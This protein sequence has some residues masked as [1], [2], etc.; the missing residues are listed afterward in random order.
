MMFNE[1]A[2][3]E[4]VVHLSIGQP[5]FSTPG[6]VIDAMVQALHDGKT[7]YALDSGV[8]EF[9]RPSAATTS[10]PRAF[11]SI[12]KRFSSLTARWRP[13]P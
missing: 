13:S 10:E 9:R 11:K 3:K 7:R 12:P 8:P 1:A 4:D 6:P 5:D 2:G